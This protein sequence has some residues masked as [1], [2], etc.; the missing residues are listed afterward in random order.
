MSPTTTKGY[1]EE[2]DIDEFIDRPLAV[3]EEEAERAAVESRH[4]NVRWWLQR[5]GLC[6][7]ERAVQPGISWRGHQMHR[8]A[9]GDSNL[10]LLTAPPRASEDGVVEHTG[11]VTA[12]SIRAATTDDLALKANT[13]NL[14][15]CMHDWPRRLRYLTGLLVPYIL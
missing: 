3:E 7:G 4:S 8:D 12:A 14:A 2:E 10:D 5:W 9:G 11:F 15:L 6:G 13:S 1:S